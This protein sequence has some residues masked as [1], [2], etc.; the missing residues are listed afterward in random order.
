MWNMLGYMH[1]RSVICTLPFV[2]TNLGNNDKIMPN[3]VGSQVLYSSLFCLPLT[4][5][6][7]LDTSIHYMGKKPVN[8]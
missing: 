4:Y 3:D 8:V 2:Q 5:D 6:I 7:E 1:T